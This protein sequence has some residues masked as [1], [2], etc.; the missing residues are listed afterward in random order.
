MAPRP[1]F[2]KHSIGFAA[3]FL[4]DWPLKL[5]RVLALIFILWNTFYWKKYIISAFPFDEMILCG[6]LFLSPQVNLSKMTYDCPF[7][8]LHYDPI[9]SPFSRQDEKMASDISCF[10][11]LVGH[12][13]T[14]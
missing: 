10:S 3:E 6:D 4:I 7:A 14:K 9:V 8:T 11:N 12:K 2:F 5:W 1:T 13:L